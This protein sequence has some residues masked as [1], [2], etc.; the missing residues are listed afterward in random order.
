MLKRSRNSPALFEVFRQHPPSTPAGR[1]G[2][3]AS[4]PT[5]GTGTATAGGRPATPAETVEPKVPTLRPTPN[6]R[7]TAASAPSAPARSYAVTPSISPASSA[8]SA[9][10]HAGRPAGEDAGGGTEG[11]GAFAA[12][13]AAMARTVRMP[14]GYVYAGSILAVGL[15]VLAYSVGL[16]H[17]KK[18]GTGDSIA[19]DG[20]RPVIEDPLLDD[21][22]SG[23]E[24][25]LNAAETHRPAGPS[26]GR[27]ADR[28]S[29]AANNAA[30]PDRNAADANAGRNRPQQAAAG[31]RMLDRDIR[32]AGLNY[33]VVERFDPEEAWAVKDFLKDNGIDAI[34]LAT[35]NPA[36]LQV[37]VAEGFQGWLSNAKAQETNNRLDRLGRE[38]KTRHGGTKDFALRMPAKH[39]G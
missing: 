22:G 1:N 12:G 5:S 21:Q 34:V 15:V 6:N 38:W 2:A 24:A 16:G 4:S 39:Q 20:G 31:G 13:R 33:I 32:Q 11:E 3:P 14:L 10:P 35:N 28:S 30:S 26:G 19:G 36:L 25:G 18:T 8:V 17:G 27:S 7:P 9:L 29:E 37:I 23:L